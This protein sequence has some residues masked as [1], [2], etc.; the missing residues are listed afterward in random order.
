MNILQNELE[1]LEKYLAE[2]IRQLETERTAAQS[3]FDCEPITDWG[4]CI[5]YGA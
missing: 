2:Y 5:G 1:R 4:G 3:C